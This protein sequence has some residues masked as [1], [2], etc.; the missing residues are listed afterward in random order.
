MCKYRNCDKQPPERKHYC[1]S[2]CQY[3]ERSL[4]KDETKHLPPVKKRNEHYMQMFTGKRVRV[5]SVSRQGK[6]VGHMVMGSMS[7]MLYMM[8]F[9]LVEVTKENIERH[10]SYPNSP[11]YVA[12][13]NGDRISKEEAL[14]LLSSRPDYRL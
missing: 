8:E 11:K 2:N 4:V 3:R 9:I 1:N 13:G 7:A 6:R 10:F 12:L 5:P 14:Q